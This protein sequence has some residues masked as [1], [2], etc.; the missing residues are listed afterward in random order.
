MTPLFEKRTWNFF[1]NKI[2]VA[3]C[4]SGVVG[5]M[6]LYSAG[7]VVSYGAIF[8]RGIIGVT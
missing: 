8:S 1:Q 7:V 5:R 2:I 3:S 4:S 6:A